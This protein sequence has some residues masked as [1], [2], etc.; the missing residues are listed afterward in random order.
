MAARSHQRQQAASCQ[1]EPADTGGPAG[2]RREQLRDQPRTGLIELRGNRRW[3]GG[4]RRSFR[5]GT[6]PVATLA[7]GPIAARETRV[8]TRLRAVEDA[9]RDAIERDGIYAPSDPTRTFR[10]LG[11]VTD[12]QIDLEAEP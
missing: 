8:A 1:S 11:H 3:R 2:P 12:R 9:Y 7:S 4:R 6:G 10:Y 5:S